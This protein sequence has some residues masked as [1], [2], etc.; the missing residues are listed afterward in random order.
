MC[1][2][3]IDEAQILALRQAYAELRAAARAVLACPEPADPAARTAWDRLRTACIP[4]PDAFVVQ[5]PPQHRM[6][7]RLPR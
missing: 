7:L 4:D 6:V 2:A 3:G 1:D 5:A